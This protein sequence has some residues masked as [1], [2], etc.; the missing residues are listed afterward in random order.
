MR[1][2]VPTKSKR[3]QNGEAVKPKMAN[4]V[5]A[6][7]GNEA[8][9]YAMKQV[10]PDVVAAYPIT[11]QTSLM[12]KFS[13]FVADGLVETEMILTES[14]HSAMSACVG[15]SAA[16][17]RTMTATSSNGLALMWEILYIA[18]GTR[19]P[20]V[21]T[22]VNRA[23]SGP[24][25]IHCDHSDS[26]GARD[27]GWIQLFSENSQEAYENLIQAVR[28]A[29]HPDVMTPVMV[30]FDGFIISHGME[31]VEIF[32]DA[33]VKKFVGGYV[34]KYPLLDTKHPVAY[35]PLDLPDYYFEHKRAQ[36][37]GMRN[38]P[39]VIL[40]VAKEFEKAF[41]TN[42]TSCG[43]EHALIEGY[44][45]DDAEYAIVLLGSTAGTARVTVDEL[46]AAGKKAGLLKIRSFRPFPEKEIAQAL[47]NVKAL[48]VMDRADGVNAIG[49]PLFNEIRAA[50]YGRV[51]TKIQNYIYGLGGR[52]TGPDTIET[53]YN[54]LFELAQPKE[55]AIYLGVRE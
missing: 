41:G 18:S 5:M 39:R 4:K 29:E 26:M 49:G 54:D 6:L 11:P 44:K 14:E 35:G 52:D 45:L 24:L 7:T 37:E 15:S 36:G 10:N 27:S 32:D 9:A 16:G 8:V 55:Q 40:E 17:A 34:P 28:I 50:L 43:L 38:A 51:N 30:C 33:A 20:I 19:L 13:E 42:H 21:M 53:V 25:N 1:E 47:K 12:E 23:L 3:D 22:L 46:R 31:N 48:A 2:G